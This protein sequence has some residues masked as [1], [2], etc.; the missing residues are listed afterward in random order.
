MTWLR[1]VLAAGLSLLLPGAGHAVLRDW[2]RALL[3]AGLYFATFWLF[4]PVERMMDAGTVSEMMDVA[5]EVD[6]LSQLTLLFITL[7]AAFDATFRALGFPPNGSSG[8]V[9]GPTCPECGKELDEDLEFCH[10]CTTRIERDPEDDPAG[11]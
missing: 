1:A 4:F 2:F 6:M 5:A 3:F 10:W 9:E 7:I 8:D 11:P